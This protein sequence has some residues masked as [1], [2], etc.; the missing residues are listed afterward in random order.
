LLRCV[1]AHHLTER[2]D[3]DTFVKQEAHN[4]PSCSS[5]APARGGGERGPLVLCHITGLL[6]FEAMTKELKAGEEG[7][8]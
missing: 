2:V 8:V 4:A 1:Y 3:V 7:E 5:R 6:V